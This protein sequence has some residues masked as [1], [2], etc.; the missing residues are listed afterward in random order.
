[1]NIQILPSVKPI[2]MLGI[3]LVVVDEEHLSHKKKILH[4]HTYVMK[5]IYVFKDSHHMI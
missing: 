2:S 3:N 4:K 5:V 1:M